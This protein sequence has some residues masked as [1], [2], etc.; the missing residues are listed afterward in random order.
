MK[1]NEKRGI[2]ISSIVA[3]MGVVGIIYTS[4][5]K[6]NVE[7]ANYMYGFGF[8]YVVIGITLI[9]YFLKLSKNKQKSDEQEN[10]YEDER[11]NSNRDF[12]CAITFKIIIWTSCIV[13]FVVTYFLRQYK[14]FSD[15]FGIFA[16]FTMIVYAIVYFF[17][18]KRN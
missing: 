10:I 18:S 5:I 11:I 4:L 3:L 15:I 12:A 16:I 14:D 17:V 7:D 8:T 9:S 2:I 13:D 6:E 1:K